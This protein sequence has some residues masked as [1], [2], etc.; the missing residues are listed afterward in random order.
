VIQIDLGA[1]FQLATDWQ[2]DMF[3]QHALTNESPDFQV[4]FGLSTRF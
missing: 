1:A 2:I 4:A 3:T